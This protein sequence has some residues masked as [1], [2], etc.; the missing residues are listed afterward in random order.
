MYSARYAGDDA[1]DEANLRKML[2]ELRGVPPRS[3]PRA[4][5]A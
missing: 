3:A 2:E 5:A 1:S 4:I